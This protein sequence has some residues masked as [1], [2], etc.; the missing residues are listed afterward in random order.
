MR[1]AWLWLGLG[2]V[3][4]WLVGGL[5]GPRPEARAQRPSSMTG[6]GQVFAFP[7]QSNEGPERVVLVDP[8]Q[9]S[10]AVYHIDRKTGAISLRSVRNVH[11]DLGL[12]DFN[13]VSPAPREIRTLLQHR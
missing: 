13:G 11:W 4:A 1:K 3:I 2:I 7:L 5:I 12:D 6:S 8:N 10:L 9:R